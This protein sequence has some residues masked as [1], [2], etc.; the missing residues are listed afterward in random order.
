ME[1]RTESYLDDEPLSRHYENRRE[2]LQIKYGSL[3]YIQWLL[4]YFT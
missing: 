3:Y 2:Y 1:K 4:L